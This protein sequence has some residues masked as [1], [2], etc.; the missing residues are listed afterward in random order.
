MS[1]TRFAL[2]TDR[3][4]GLVP[5]GN[6]TERAFLENHEVGPLSVLLRDS[7]IMRR[8]PA[9][10]FATCP[11]DPAEA[12]CAR[13]RKARRRGLWRDEVNALRMACSFREDDATL[14]TLYAFAL[15]RMGRAVEAVEAL[16]H[17]LWLRER[18]CD[19]RRASVTRSLLAAMSSGSRPTVRAA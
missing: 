2:P 10:T 9:R 12:A 11:V 5:S 8:R 6:L 14:W 15:Q 13:A 3:R 1:G 16:R 17:A 19:G 7:S 4:I 18:C